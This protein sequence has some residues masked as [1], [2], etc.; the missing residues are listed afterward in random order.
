MK[1]E[2]L[3]DI[4]TE[5]KSDPLKWSAPEDISQVRY[6]NNALRNYATRIQKAL[7]QDVIDESKE[8]QKPGNCLFAVPVK[9]GAYTF[10]ECS[11]RKCAWDCAL[12][13]D[14]VHR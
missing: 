7:G 4:L 12:C 11:K 14:F 13:N 2:S 1:N 6:D 10:Y 9:D 8:V 3:N 5:M